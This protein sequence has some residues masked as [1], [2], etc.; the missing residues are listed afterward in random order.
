M[1]A[2]AIKHLVRTVRSATPRPLRLA[3]GRVGHYLTADMRDAVTFPSMELA[4]RTLRQHGFAPRFCVDVGAYRGE[5]TRMARSVFPEAGVLMIEAQE[6]KRVELERLASQLPGARCEIA[7]LAAETGERVTF[8]EMET[9][10]SVFAECSPYPRTGVVKETRTLDDVLADGQCPRVDL[11]KLDVQGF[12]LEVL[13][14]AA[15]ALSQAEAVLTEVSLV[16]V[17][18]GVPS[19]AD[20]VAFFAARGFRLFDFCSQV[21]RRDGV[22]WQTDLLF[23]RS[24][25][26]ALPRPELTRENWG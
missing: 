12:E 17:N 9:G 16:P 7:I 18:A 2:S 24:D 5:W 1:A 23:L 26:P 21:R 4:L 20:V 19:F 14:G 11:L 25:S 10:S 15:R 6:G 13:K 8:H 3:A 22:L